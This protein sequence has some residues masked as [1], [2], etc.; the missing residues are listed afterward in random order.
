M[1]QHEITSQL[2]VNQHRCVNNFKLSFETLYGWQTAC[3][4]SASQKLRLPCRFYSQ[5]LHSF[6][7]LS[8]CDSC[9]HASR[10]RPRLHTSSFTAPSAP[11]TG[12]GTVAL[13]RPLNS[14]D[15]FTRP[16]LCSRLDQPQFQTVTC[17]NSNLRAL[18]TN[19]IT[20]VA[21]RFKLLGRLC[22][23]RSCSVLTVC[24]APV[25]REKV[26]ARVL[27]LRV[28]LATLRLSL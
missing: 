6:V 19:K 23:S 12:T 13:Y 8:Y 5:I 15:R 7:R 27:L 10:I 11:S 4:A 16:L 22:E 2:N 18:M 25:V 28:G 9:E 24:S 21:S 3:V 20:S 14:I 26:S 17:K 1:Y